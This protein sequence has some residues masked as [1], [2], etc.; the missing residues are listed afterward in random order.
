MKIFWLLLLITFSNYSQS[1]KAALK[2]Y[3]R[4]AETS[5]NITNAKVILEG[6]NLPQ[7]TS[8]YDEK[9]KFYFF[10]KIPYGYNTVIVNHKK[11]NEKGFQNA[12]G[13]PQNL[14]LKLR[15]AINVQYGF[16]NNSEY[17]INNNFY[18][19][20]PY[21]IVIDYSDEISYNEFILLMQKIIKDFDL[22][23]ELVNPYLERDRIEFNNFKNQEI[24]YPFIKSTSDDEYK[25]NY[26][27]PLDNGTSSIGNFN[28][29]NA[30]ISFF[31]R[32]KDG[33]KFK[34]FNDPIINKI[35]KIKNGKFEV[36]LVILNKRGDERYEYEINRSDFKIRDRLNNVFNKKNKV[37]SSKVFFY[38]SDFRNV[39]KT[40]RL[41]YIF[42]KQ[43]YVIP[44]KHFVAETV[45][46][47]DNK[48]FILIKNGK[49]IPIN[50]ISDEF[51]NK[52]VPYVEDSIGLGILDLYEYYSK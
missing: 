35:R 34:R 14:N 42:K 18:V 46:G 1:Y 9:G 16:E 11:Y 26:C 41:P 33:S 47:G 31:F 22:D 49:N 23:I 10:D 36:S 28:M 20:D 25:S 30:N 32:K 24:G 3:L 51:S 38:N 45:K 44:P 13:L 50:L 29:D 39:N 12:K 6:I 43:Y 19:E 7:L 5:Q 48:Q 52:E 27:L 40:Y 2:V 17:F 15:R 37:D 21:K 8:R 4:D